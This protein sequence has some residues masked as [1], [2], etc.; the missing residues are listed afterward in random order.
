MNGRI[1]IIQQVRY[2]PGIAYTNNL[3]Q[4]KFILGEVPDSKLPL[5]IGILFGV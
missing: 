5:V 1:I 4:S 2:P 3:L